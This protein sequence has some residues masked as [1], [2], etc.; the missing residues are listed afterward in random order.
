MP[1]RATRPQKLAARSAQPNVIERDPPGRRWTMRERAT[2]AEHAPGVLEGRPRA[3]RRDKAASGIVGSA[4]WPGW[5]GERSDPGALPA[6]RLRSN[7]L[8]IPSRAREVR[9]VKTR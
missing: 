3:T 2:V 9:R 6:D 4:R 7:Q 5:G 8:G 1:P